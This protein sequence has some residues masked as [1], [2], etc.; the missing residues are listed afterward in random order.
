MGNTVS[1]PAKATTK[2]PE[3]TPS[4]VFK[5]VALTSACIGQHMDHVCARIQPLN[6]K[7]GRPQLPT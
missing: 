5:Q 1:E 2:K 6:A 3:Q 7:P 4:E